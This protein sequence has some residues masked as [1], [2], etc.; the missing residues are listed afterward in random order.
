MAV[1]MPIAGRLYDKIGMR[2]LAVPGMAL[3]GYG[4]WLLTDINPDMTEGDVVL[5]TCVRAAGMGLAMMPV[6]TGGM[7]VLP[8]SAVNQGSA[9]N[10]VSR[11][12][13][14]AIGLAAVSAMAS[15]QQTQLFADRSAFITA[16]TLVQH[17]VQPPTPTG[18][19]NLLGMYGVHQRLQLQ[20]LGDAYGDIFLV[21]AMLCGIGAVLALALPSRRSATAVAPSPPTPPPPTPPSATTEPEPERTTPEILHSVDEPQPHEV[22]SQG[23]GR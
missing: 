7:A 2:W 6:M 20:V 11:Q 10:N 17:G 23:A 18:D 1:L 8:Q 5:W 14:G 15:I 13:A 9:W 4:T 19:G 21:T 16:D 3:A 12:V 22:V